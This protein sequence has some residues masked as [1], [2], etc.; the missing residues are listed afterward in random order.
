MYEISY[1]NINFCIKLHSFA[2]Q[3][4]SSYSST[5]I[6]E[7]NIDQERHQSNGNHVCTNCENIDG[8]FLH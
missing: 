2:V 3:I 5:I 8:Y 6:N 1:F 4:F 7:V